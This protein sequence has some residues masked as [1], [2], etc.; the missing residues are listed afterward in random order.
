MAGR[1][2]SIA[3][4]VLLAGVLPLLEGCQNRQREQ[5]ERERQARLA[6]E[7]AQRRQLDAV[8][9]RCQ[10][11]QK[12]LQTL[13]NQ[14]TSAEAGL[15]RLEQRSYQPTSRP[16]PPDPAELQRYTISDQELEMERHQQ[17]LE[18][19]EATEAERRRRWRAT[20]ASER[21]LLTSRL[22]NARARLAQ[23]NPAVIQGMAVQGAVLQTYLSC[24]RQAL[25]K[26]SLSPSNAGATATRP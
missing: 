22:A 20:Q 13:A 15:S 7:A 2:R 21:D 19:W 5:A 26:L 14:L 17:A 9:E 11:N 6:Q 4:A 16:Q 18:A 12:Q 3:L 1:R 24:D 23:L 10:A 25:A 8:V